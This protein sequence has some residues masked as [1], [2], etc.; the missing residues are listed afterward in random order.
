MREIAR[1]AGG[2]HPST[3]SLALRDAPS[4]SAGMRKRIQRLAA[5]AGY[6]RDPWLDA[7]NARRLTHRAHRTQPVIAWIVDLESRSALLASARD[8][9]MWRGA[10]KTA[11]TLHFGIEAF[12]LRKSG[13]TAKRLESI[14]TARGIESV[15]LADHAMPSAT[16]AWWDRFS[17]VTVFGGASLPRGSAVGADLR[18]AAR[19][20]TLRARELG[21]RRIGM[22]L[23][24]D[25]GAGWND[26]LTAGYLLE[27]SLTGN[28][29]T[30]RPEVT[31]ESPQTSELTAW[32][33]AKAIDFVLS[34]WPEMGA[35][36]SAAKSGRV[37]KLPW[38]SLDVTDAAA[39]APGVVLPHER[40]GRFAIEQVVNL[41]RTH[42]RGQ[43]GR[44]ATT[45][46][47]VGWR[48]A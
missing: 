34:D 36:L 4:I 3:V 18:Q 2:V 13:V 30:L 10:S 6:R 7:F 43:R 40:I 47:P 28:A 15:V 41:A 1:L 17:L 23:R 25:R 38:V 20:A 14:L 31:T 32:I 33:E 21:G 24:D 44:V 12:Y 22:W 16:A 37:R 39:N 27:Q 11:E 9:A 42:Q 46:V 48:D 19:L 29:A 26:L 8:A 5:R 35:R 45:F